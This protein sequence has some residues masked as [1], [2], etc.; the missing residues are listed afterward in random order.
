MQQIFITCQN[1]M[2]KDNPFQEL[3]P[4]GPQVTI[5]VQDNP[6]TRQKSETGDR[7]GF[8]ASCIHPTRLETIP[9]RPRQSRQSNGTMWRGGP[10]WFSN[11]KSRHD[12]APKQPAEALP[13]SGP[14]DANGARFLHPQ[15]PKNIGSTRHSFQVAEMFCRKTTGWFSLPRGADRVP[16]YPK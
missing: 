6:I 7:G 11:S 3:R 9:K 8:L 14:G 5:R 2:A 16:K 4:T 15:D 1:T 13:V 12:A 10:P